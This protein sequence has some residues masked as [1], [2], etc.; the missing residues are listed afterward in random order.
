VTERAIGRGGDLEAV[1][2]LGNKLPKHTAR[3]AVVLT[4]FADPDA[5]KIL[6][7]AMGSGIVLA[8]HYAAESLRLADS[9]QVSADTRLAEKVRLWL[10]RNWSDLL[11]SLPDIYQHGPNAV[12]E[13]AR[14]DRV[15][16]TLE[17]H[18]HLCRVLGGAEIRAVRRRDVCVSS[19]R[20]RPELLS[21]RYDACGWI[22]SPTPLRDL[23][24]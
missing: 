9:A 16:R 7:G 10:L 8:E 2:G 14:A 12:R 23:K 19:G 15:V 22:R 5:G 21:G 11:V 20:V 24:L 3:I 18:G 4:L 13:K 17:D 6:S 1:R